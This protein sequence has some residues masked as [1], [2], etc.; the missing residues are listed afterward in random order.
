MSTERKGKGLSAQQARAILEKNPKLRAD[1][2]DTSWVLERASQALGADK[3]KA[4]RDQRWLALDI[5]A[6]MDEAQTELDNEQRALDEAQAA[7]DKQRA[8]LTQA[9]GKRVYLWFRANDPTMKAPSTLAT[10]KTRAAFFKKLG[11]KL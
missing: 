2:K 3:D 10:L 11:F 9:T 4:Q 7:L 5:E 6:A 1:G 8:A